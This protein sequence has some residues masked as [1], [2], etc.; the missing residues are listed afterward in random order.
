[1]T[2]PNDKSAESAPE[3]TTIPR[4]VIENHPAFKGLVKQIDGLRKER[5]EQE[6]KRE[7]ERAELEAKKAAEAGNYEQA[8]AAYQKTAAEEIANL[9][10][11]AEQARKSAVESRL[12]A[13]MAAMGVHD[14][15]VVRAGITALYWAQA[16]PAE[17]SD[18]LQSLGDQL[19]KTGKSALPPAPGV[20]P[21]SRGGLPGFGDLVKRWL[22]N[23]NS[24]KDEINNL[25]AEKR[26][27]FWAFASEQARK[28]KR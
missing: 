12:L 5:E 19:P 18:F 7:T 13:E 6:R 15:P 23:D 28:G 11:Q 25:P 16:E 4:E 24:V 14:S 10:A 2:E 17:P 20:S 27:E 1:M 9:R 22:Y 21:A 26:N 3:S 8:L